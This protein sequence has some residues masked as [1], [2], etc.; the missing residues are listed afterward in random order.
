MHYDNSTSRYS[1]NRHLRLSVALGL[2]ST[3]IAAVLGWVTTL[4]ADPPPHLLP[5]PIPGH[6]SGLP[7]SAVHPQPPV[8]H[9]D[10]IESS[11]RIIISP[12]GGDED[13]V[14]HGPPGGRYQDGG[15]SHAGGRPGAGSPDA[16]PPHDGSRPHLR[17]PNRPQLPG[18]NQFPYRGGVAGPDGMPHDAF[19]GPTTDARR[20]G[21]H[22]FGNRPGQSGP[23]GLGFGGPPTPHAPLDFDQVIQSPAVVKFLELTQQNLELKSQLKIQA[24]ESDARI[25]MQDVQHE[26]ESLKEQLRRSQAELKE[27]ARINETLSKRVTEL[28]HRARLLEARLMSQADHS[29]D[30]SAKPI[31]LDRLKSMLDRLEESLGT[32]PEVT[33]TIVVE[34]DK[35]EATKS[36]AGTVVVDSN[37]E[38][39][40][41]IP[42]VIVPSPPQ[43]VPATSPDDVEQASASEE[44]SE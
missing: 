1:L 35:S 13:A 2:P 42:P 43:V 10:G 16:G 17:P 14:Q 31:N 41:V 24:I 5:Q 8:I 37:Q 27:A 23:G 15:R 32:I 30:Q 36:V 4:S 7:V 34:D 44:K 39:D 9:H 25:R 26:A 12:S 3:L 33:A 22:P 28:E 29:N 18:D 20:F 21:P 6:A 19:G 11:E 40:V 38:V